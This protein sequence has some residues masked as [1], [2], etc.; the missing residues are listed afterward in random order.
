MI[1]AEK[2]SRSA[3]VFPA[4]VI[5]VVAMMV[6]PLPSLV[7]DLLLSVNIA[8]GVLILLA[9]MNATR[10]LD[11]ASFPSIL[12]LATLFRLGLNVSTTRQILG[13]GSAGSVITSF[14]Q[15]VVGGSL[16]V[17][18]VIFFI[19]VIIQFVVIT[20]GSS[21]VSEVAA[22]FTLDAMPGKQMA[23]DA[24]LNAGLISDGEARRRRNEIA[25]EADFFGAMDGASKFV[26]GDAIAGLIITTV[27]LIGG[28]AIGMTSMGLSAGE[29][30]KRFALLTIGDG[31]V[32]QIPALLISIAAGIIVT[33]SSASEHDLGSAVAG[34][35]AKQQRAFQIAGVAL[36]AL[37]ALPGL[38]LLPFAF[39]GGLLVLVSVRLQV[40]RPTEP[41]K[42]E[43]EVEAEEPDDPQQLIRNARVEPLTLEIANDMIDLVD[44][45]QGGDLLER[46]K[47]LRRKVAIETGFVMPTIRT[48]DNAGLNFGSYRI[49]A[50]GV[51]IAEGV[52]PAG[53]VLVIDDELGR[54]PGEEI[55]E[56]VFGLAAKWVPESFKP[57][58]EAAGATVVDRSAVITTHLGEVLVGHSADLFD[59]QQMNDLID[60][61]KESQPSIIDD[62]ATADVPMPTIQWIFRDLLQSQV[63]IKD[64]TRILEVISA[65]YPRCQDP[66]VIVEE[67]R[68]A[69]GAAIT[70]ANM[71]SKE[72][73]VIS[74]D[75]LLEQELLAAL[76]TT[77]GS[78]LLDAATLQTVLNEIVE[79]SQRA[80][81]NG[82]NP[83]LL[84]S[85]QLRRP[86]AALLDRIASAPRVL[87]FKEVGNH[88]KMATVGTISLP[89]R[90]LESDR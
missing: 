5:G 39:I 13:T 41:L 23:I 19:L 52:A 55:F 48:R 49:L 84:C 79:V 90:Q 62:I 6:V 68:L 56:P 88:V 33:R 38:P 53:R 76:N 51:T 47:G 50:H 26:K 64:S 32:S 61:A 4:A 80:Q 18:L 16:V 63:P 29:A 43:P 85:P 59:R 87:S 72:L 31:L 2:R 71:V 36:A 81:N 22:R 7:L 1:A 77:N 70:E 3:V 89:Q 11:L 86:L 66:E 75:G 27:N 20:N 24:D 57:T 44:E 46:I 34:E 28:L 69:L 45:T 42:E 65:S 25:Q 67:V 9:S 60:V 78:E 14:G 83:V 35:F 73:Q 82:N 15:S 54:W 30:M 58:I 21:R 74:M 17:G 10:V 40:E 12:L 8:A 37:G